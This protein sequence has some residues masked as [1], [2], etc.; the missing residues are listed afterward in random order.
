M[1]I[2]VKDIITM[3]EFR[4]H[5]AEIMNEVHKSQNKKVVTINGKPAIQ[6][7]N[8][9]KAEDIENEIQDLRKENDTLKTLFGLKRGLEAYLK[10]DYIEQ[11]EAKKR[12]ERFLT[13]N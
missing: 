3:T 13:N 2:S 10:G 4:T 1:T 6:I 9:V 5:L 12:F 11:E 7:Q 8:A